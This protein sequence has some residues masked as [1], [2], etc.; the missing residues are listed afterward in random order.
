[1][2][3]ITNYANVCP[4]VHVKGAIT[5]E[6]CE[7]ITE[8]ILDF[9]ATGPEM[10][11]SNDLCWRSPL[12]IKEQYGYGVNEKTFK[13]VQEVLIEAIN[14]Y[15]DFLFSHNAYLYK[16]YLEDTTDYQSPKLNAWFNVNKMGGE[17]LAH[18]HA[19]THVSGVI[20]FQGSG[21]GAISF[22][23][24]ETM[25]HMVP[26]NWPFSGTATYLPEDGDIILFPSYLIHWVEPNPIKR[27]RI[28]MAFNVDYTML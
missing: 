11:S 5:K 18:S 14:K 25:Y 6:T 27:E 1:M 8:E 22:K 15:N 9:K 10:A 28:N 23:S 13:D 17:N 12:L 7:S 16:L 21:T 20:Y 3:I 19:G 4:I 2:E 26:H 24:L